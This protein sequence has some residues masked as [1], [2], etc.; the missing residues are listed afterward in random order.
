MTYG[1]IFDWDGLM[2]DSEPLISQSH[3]AIIRRHGKTPQY[4]ENGFVH[5]V[6]LSTELNT[7]IIK[8]FY[9]IDTPLEEMTRERIGILNN[10]ITP[11]TLQPQP[12][13][14]D[15]LDTLRAYDVPLAVASGSYR[16]TLE[17]GLA[18]LGLRNYFTTVVSGEDVEEGKPNPRSH[19]LAGEGIGILA[20]RC[21]VLEDSATGIEGAKAAGMPAIAVPNR[22]TNNQDFR[23]AEAVVVS[24]GQVSVGLLSSLVEG[25]IQ[26]EGVRREREMHL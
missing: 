1:V 22:Y 20:P 13:L 19:L 25:K 8:D 24:L 12:G 6:G 14:R 26:R 23:R 5:V 15:L 3:E 16:T 10:L 11:E 4:N 18:I 17:K 9:Q 21:V 7:Q 2:V